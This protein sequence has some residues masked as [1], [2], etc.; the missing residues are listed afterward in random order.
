MNYTRTYVV[1]VWGSQCGSSGSKHDRHIV[2]AASACDACTGLLYWGELVK[3]EITVQ[4]TGE[5]FA[6]K[7]DDPVSGKYTLD[8]DNPVVKGHCA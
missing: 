5:K 4:S 3:L 6:T 2:R 1:D 7:I 8:V